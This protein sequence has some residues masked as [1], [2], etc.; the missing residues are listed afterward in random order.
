MTDAGWIMKRILGVILLG[1]AATASAVQ[2]TATNTYDAAGRLVQIVTT[3]TG[4]SAKLYFAYDR[5]GNLTF[6]SRY[7]PGSENADY[8]TD[9]MQDATEF[10]DFGTLTQGADDDFDGDRF[11][12]LDEYRA[13]TSP[14]NAASCFAFETLLRQGSS[15]GF[16]VR[17]QSVTGK[18]YRVDRLGN[19]L[20]G[21]WAL[22]VGSVTGVPPQ[23][24]YTD[25]TAVGT[26]PWVYRIQLE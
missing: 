9:G 13:G 21:N 3:T 24:V 1:A 18:V 4:T 15:T 2:E 26:G 5:A 25:R 23:N 14:T 20:T 6:E 17:W 19:L 7:A 16:V 11:G 12:N 22:V 8:D 10:V